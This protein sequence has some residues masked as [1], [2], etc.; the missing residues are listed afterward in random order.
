[1]A[2]TFLASE[3]AVQGALVADGVRIDLC[4][5]MDAESEAYDTALINEIE[6]FIVDELLPEHVGKEWICLIPSA[7]MC[8]VLCCTCCC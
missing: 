8:S 6:T 4:I 7:I 2:N 5:F 1:M 3:L